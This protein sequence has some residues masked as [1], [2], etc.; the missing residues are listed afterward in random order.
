M[1]RRAGE[2]K[3]EKH[4][5]YFLTAVVDCGKL[6]ALGEP[7][8]GTALRFTASDATLPA[9]NPVSSRQATRPDDSSPAAIPIRKAK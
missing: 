5:H 6:R 3:V 4:L 7:A 8:L 2:Q 1:F 9:L